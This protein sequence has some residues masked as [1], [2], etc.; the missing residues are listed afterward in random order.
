MPRFASGFLINVSQT[1]PVRKFSAISMVIP[2]SDRN[3]R[4]GG[5]L[6]RL[7][8]RTIHATLRFRIPHKR[9]PDKPGTQI[10]SH[11]H[12][13]SCIDS[14]DVVIEPV[15]ERVEGVDESILTPGAGSVPRP[16]IS[17]NAKGSLWRESQRSSCRARN[18]GAINGP[19]FRRTAPDHITV[20]L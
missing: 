2:V 5:W 17:Q 16:D 11:Q 6:V 15:L 9:L 20:G 19:H 7:E 14:D 12:G 8:P 13:N 18:D 1:N 4:C 10:L 3:L